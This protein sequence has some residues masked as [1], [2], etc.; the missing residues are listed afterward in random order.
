M[1]TF[2]QCTRSLSLPSKFLQV[3]KCGRFFYP[4]L[5]KNICPL[6]STTLDVNRG[7]EPSAFPLILIY[8][9]GILAIICFPSISGLTFRRHF[10]IYVFWFCNHNNICILY[11][12]PRFKILTWFVCLAKL[13]IILFMTCLIMPSHRHRKGQSNWLLSFPFFNVVQ[14][15]PQIKSGSYQCLAL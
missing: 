10:G 13:A 5:F 4:M 6:N 3:T 11:V 8:K 2:T 14:Q 15:N 7:F 9:Q 1:G 12:F